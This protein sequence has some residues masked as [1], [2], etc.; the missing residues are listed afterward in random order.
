M[1]DTTRDK[2]ILLAV[3]LTER[4]AIKAAAAAE[5]LTVQQWARR[6]LFPAAG[7]PAPSRVVPGARVVP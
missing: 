5:D 4:E 3:T 6:I 1:E 2:G 7:L